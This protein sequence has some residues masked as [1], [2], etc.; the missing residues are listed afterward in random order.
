MPV[1][2]ACKVTLPACTCPEYR[3]FLWDHVE[4]RERALK[5][6][7]DP[8]VTRAIALNL[9]PRD[10]RDYLR[11]AAINYSGLHIFLDQVARV[12]AL[13]TLTIN[14]SVSANVD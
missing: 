6:M 12:L 1:A 13:K 5:G 7:R 4:T 2:G 9:E 8:A 3:G 14:N 11:S 10:L